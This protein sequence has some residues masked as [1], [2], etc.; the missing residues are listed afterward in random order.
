MKK[1]IQRG[2][3]V[4]CFLLWILFLA[5]PCNGGSLSQRIDCCTPEKPCDLNHGDCDTNEDCKGGL[6]CGNNNCGED[7][8]W[9]GADCCTNGM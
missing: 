7:F 4:S 1:Q 8:T 9:S 6:F 5:S 3:N 2:K